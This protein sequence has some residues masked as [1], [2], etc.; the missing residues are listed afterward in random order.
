M[1]G[2]IRHEIAK[3]VGHVNAGIV[4]DIADNHVA[5]GVVAAGA[6]ILATD[7]AEDPPSPVDRSHRHAD[8]IVENHVVGLFPDDH[9]AV[10]L[11]F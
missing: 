2:V 5:H 7:V 3:I 8:P 4:K 1:N 10:D 11:F 9:R 6:V